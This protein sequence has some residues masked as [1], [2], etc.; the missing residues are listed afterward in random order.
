MKRPDRTGTA[1][2]TGTL[3][4]IRARLSRALLAWSGLWG[5]AVAATI[6]LAVPHEVNEL[7]DD[8]LQA[9]AEV[10]GMLL[11]TQSTGVVPQAPGGARAAPAL[12]SERFAWQ[13]VGPD[14]GLL[15]RSAQAPD[16]ALCTTATA[17]FSDTEEWRVFGAALGG[18][19]RMLYVAQTLAERREAQFE[20]AF[21]SALATLAIG[22]L[23]HLWLRARVRHEL[24]PLETLS[25]RL[26]RH[27]PTA[28]AGSLGIAERE[29]LQPVHAAIDDLGRRLAQRIATERAFSAH[30]AH[31]L[32]TPLAGIDAQLAVALRECPP[33]LQQ[34]L[35]RSREAA[36]RLQRVVAAL[37]ILF[38]GNVELRCPPVDLSALI[39]RLPVEGLEVVATRGA[40]VEAD[41]DLL[42]AAL[43]NL[44][45]NALRY[46]ATRVEVSVP[47]EATLR[48]HDNGP[49]VSTERRLA[50][51]RAIK[52]EADAPGTGLGLRL[53][54][55]VA[56]AHHGD[57]RL[58]MTS[59]GFAVEL[60]LR[61]VG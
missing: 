42:A 48:V 9:S 50:L 25:H 16:V 28:A 11:S 49:G 8:T 58:P 21:S 6:M 36:A 5:A 40:V 39:A 45:D 30:A 35:R 51:Q 47:T 23:G 12:P 1:I 20:V 52:G 10:L 34:R 46:G 19:G 18:D 53:A 59:Q 15:L 26:A 2:E 55:L 27:D 41:A 56:R 61:P 13:L 31:A 37:L 57:L 44:F 7:L 4:S 60:V 22:L 38:R 3:P 43:L 17:G 29:E 32:R 24:S 33:A 54:A 14:G